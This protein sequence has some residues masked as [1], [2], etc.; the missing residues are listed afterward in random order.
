MYSRTAFM[1]AVDRKDALGTPMIVC[2]VF[3]ASS[4]LSAKGIPVCTKFRWRLSHAGNVPEAG[5]QSPQTFSYSL[6]VCEVSESYSA[7]AHGA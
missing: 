4:R 2:C 7:F 5:H 3:A 6:F 1:A